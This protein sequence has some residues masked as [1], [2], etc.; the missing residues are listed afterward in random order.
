MDHVRDFRERGYA[1]IRGLFSPAEVAELAPAFDRI[2]AAGRA[3]RTSYRHGNVFFK[4]TN[5]D[6]LGP[7]MRM[8][9]WPAYIDP[10]LERYRR[11]PRIVELLSPLIGCDLKQII[12]Q[13]HWKP[14]GAANV[15]FGYHQ[16]IRS[17]R[18]RWACLLYTSDAAD[19]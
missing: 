11:D 17:R 18:P 3:H 16:D 8:M 12:N 4:I 9:Q 19:E 7:L 6:N 1:V 15:E 13:M 5:D 14:P 10:V 2:A